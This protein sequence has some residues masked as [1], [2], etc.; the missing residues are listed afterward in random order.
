MYY[1]KAR[2]KSHARIKGEWGRGVGEERVLD[3]LEKFN[4]HIKFTKNR[5][6][7]PFGKI[8][9]IRIMSINYLFAKLI[10]LFVQKIS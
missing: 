7:S 9:W 2:N 3:P 10:Y 1:S 4:S 8:I 5:S 6:R